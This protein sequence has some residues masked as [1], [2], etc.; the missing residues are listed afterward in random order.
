[1]SIPTTRHRS[2]PRIP[3]LIAIGLSLA[4]VPLA[5]AVDGVVEL[6]QATT[7]GFGILQSGSYRLTSDL[8]LT[9]LGGVVI[10]ADDVT[11]DLNGFTVSSTNPTSTDG[12][13]AGGKGIEIRNGTVR[14]FGRHGI[15]SPGS[16]D[17]QGGVRVIGVTVIGNGADGIRLES[18]G[19]LVDGC[20]SL[21]NGGTGILVGNG[22][23]IINSVARLNTLHGL[24]PRSSAYRS[25]VLT[26]NNGG[27]QNAQV[28]GG[29]QLGPNLCGTDTIC[30]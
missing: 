6:N 24:E 3:C 30:P 12:I 23:L 11:L 27:D 16:A 4:W 9:G 20:I 7:G 28:M 17:S 26:G 5:F 10:Q 21:G 13:V 29:T 15:F 25:N 18:P 14:G 1:M 2:F 19:N 22:S 8:V